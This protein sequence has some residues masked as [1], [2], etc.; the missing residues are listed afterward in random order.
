[1]A[2]LDGSAQALRLLDGEQRRV[3][4]RRMRDAEAVQGGK[5]LI[6]GGGHRRF[7]AIFPRGCKV[8]TLLAIGTALAAGLLGRHTQRMRV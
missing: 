3:A 1:M 8:L 5:E 6:R 7:L 2:A 4:D